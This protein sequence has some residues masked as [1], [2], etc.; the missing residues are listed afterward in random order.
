MLTDTFEAGGHV[1]KFLV[2]ALLNT[3]KHAI[4][5]ITPPDNTSET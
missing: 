2:A 5:A 3:G 4:N 1:G